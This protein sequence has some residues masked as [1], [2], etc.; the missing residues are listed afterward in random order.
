[1]KRNRKSTPAQPPTG[2][3]RTHPAGDTRVAWDYFVSFLKDRGDRVTLSRRFVFDRVFDRHD[4][5]SADELADDLAHGPRRVSRGTIYRTLALMTE[6]GLV[7]S[8]RDSSAHVHYE[9]VHGHEH[10]EHLIC[11]Q[12]GRFIEFV[13]SGVQ[14]KITRVCRR[15]EFVQRTHRIVILGTCKRCARQPSDHRA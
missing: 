12:C 8:F 14:D 2:R 3:H 1:M 10:H 11:E 5:F 6:A 13:D 7:R 9:H 4:H 15:H